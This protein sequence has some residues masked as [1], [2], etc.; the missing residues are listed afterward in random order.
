MQKDLR[1]GKMGCEEQESLGELRELPE[2][3][4]QGA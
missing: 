4:W 2:A 3:D 1:E